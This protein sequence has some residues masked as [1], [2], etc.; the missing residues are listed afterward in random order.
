M[1]PVLSTLPNPNPCACGESSTVHA[2]HLFRPG[3]TAGS[4]AYAHSIGLLK[5]DAWLSHSTELTAADIAALQA[6]GASVAHNPSAIMS[7]RGRCPVPEL[8]D[9]GVNV[10]ISSDGTAPDRSADPFRHMQQCM[11]YHRRHFRDDQ[12]S[13]RGRPGGRTAGRAKGG[14]REGGTEGGSG[15]AL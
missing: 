11:H 13:R 8:I 15:G 5:P 7:I 4:V 14:K 12:V 10:A 1:L 6:S 2:A 9:A 3:H